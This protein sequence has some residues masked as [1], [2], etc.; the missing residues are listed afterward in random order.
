MDNIQAYLVSK[1]ISVVQAMERID[2]GRRGLVFVVDEEQHLLGCITDGDIRRWLIKTADMTATLAQLLYRMP[3]YFVEGDN[4]DP[5]EYMSQNHIT[6]VPVVDADMRVL[7]IHFASFYRKK[8]TPKKC[9]ALKNVPVIIMAGGKGTRL[10][11]F[12][13]ILPKPLIPIGEIPIVERIMDR[14]AEYGV[15]DFYMTVNYK[16][17]MIKS[18]FDDLQPNYHIH[19]VDE[20]KP[21]GTAGS[22][23]L[24]QETFTKPVIVTNCDSLIENDLGEIYERHIRSGNAM[25]I[26]ASLKNIQIPYG[27]LD[28]TKDGIVERMREKPSLSQFINTGMYVVDPA[29]LK[30]I[31]KDTVYHMTHLAED[32]MKQNMQVGMFPISEDSFLDM[33]EFQEMK[34]M[35]EKLKL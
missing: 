34:R 24:I 27:V 12:T 23:T 10:Y 1:E 7:D 31:P 14:F 22:I 30:M 5:Q 3:K 25:T 32:A 8:G 2:A 11:P 19:Y 4:S 17:G 16:R 9:D 28:I 6:A 33:G 15:T 26:V 20:Y 29:L 35:E 21:S 13:K 18:Y